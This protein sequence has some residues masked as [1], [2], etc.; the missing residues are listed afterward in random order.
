MNIFKKSSTIVFFGA[1]M[2]GAILNVCNAELDQETEE[3]DQETAE[4][5][6]ETIDQIHQQVDRAYGAASFVRNKR[7]RPVSRRVG[8]FTK[9]TEVA[10]TAASRFDR[11]AANNPG[12]NLGKYYSNAAEVLR[13]I[14]LMLEIKKPE[15]STERFAIKNNRLFKAVWAI[16]DE[17]NATI[18]AQKVANKQ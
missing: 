12:T 2:G 16:V 10:L 3:F 9:I 18:A 4:L 8:S 6:Q 5:D 14:E 15:E 11:E 1:M 13:A 17:V 7:L